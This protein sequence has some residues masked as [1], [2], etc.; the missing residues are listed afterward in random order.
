M[1]YKVET[2]DKSNY[3]EIVDVWEASVRATHTFLTE[4]DIQ[5]F[6]PL[7][8]EQYL[9]AV[10]LRCVKD[11]QQKILGFLG[12]AEKKA[13]MLFLLPEMRGKGIGTALMD[14]AVKELEVDK[15]DVNEDNP[16]ATRF[17]LN[18]GFQIVSRSETD[19]SGK[20]FPILHMELKKHPLN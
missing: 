15:V 4:D 3:K 20:P 11:D 8:L 10:E 5:Y 7:I 12:V 18:Y 9:D 17:Y 2:V 14:F 1:S 16:E 6:K 13:E 19:P